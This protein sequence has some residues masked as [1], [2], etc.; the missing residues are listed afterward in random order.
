MAGSGSADLPGSVCL[1]DTGAR[2]DVAC[3]RPHNSVCLVV[4]VDATCEDST[5]VGST[6]GMVRVPSLVAAQAKQIEDM[7]SQYD[8]AQDYFR[9]MFESDIDPTNNHSEQQVRHCVIDRRPFY[10]ETGLKGRAAMRASDTTSGCGLQLPPAGNR[11]E[12]SFNSCTNRSVRSL[13]GSQPPRLL[14]E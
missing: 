10:R 7:N 2:S 5:V 11:D 8:M 14:H 3:K 1:P 13:S 9:F 4:V 6:V 12:A